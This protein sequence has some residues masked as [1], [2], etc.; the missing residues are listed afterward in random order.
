MRHFILRH[1]LIKEC[2]LDLLKLLKYCKISNSDVPKQIYEQSKFIEFSF[3]NCFKEKSSDSPSCSICKES[4]SNYFSVNNFLEQSAEICKTFFNLTS[5]SFNCK[6]TL[7]TDGISIFDKSNLTI[8]PIYMAFNN[9]PYT[10]RYSLGNIAIVGIYYGNVKPDMQILFQKAFSPYI[11]FLNSSYKYKNILFTFDLKYL[12]CDKPAKSMCLNFQSHNAFYFCPLCT[13]TTK[14]EFI[15]NIRHT[16]IPL[17]VMFNSEKRT[18]SG[19]LALA[20]SAES[21]KLPDYG[22]FVT[23]QI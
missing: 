7:Y 12:V 14:V 19:F 6:F 2:S 10:F 4:F 20:Y 5:G 22:V 1:N 11:S 18:H 13:A 21:L 17:D 8:W 15:D 3:C 23:Y 16:Y 9:I